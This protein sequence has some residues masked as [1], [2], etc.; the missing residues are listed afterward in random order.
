MLN[1]AT[2]LVL[3]LAPLS[4]HARDSQ[5]IYDKL[6]VSCHA[7]DGKGNPEKA[8]TLKIDPILLNLG[9]R[10]EEDKL[11]KEQTK[12]ITLHGKDKMPAYEK[13]LKAEEVDPLVDFVYD[14]SAKARGNQ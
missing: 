13:K 7:A 1:K 8:K 14:L 2:A 10:T 3:V 11:T 5:A 6:C 9:R 12:E 4:A